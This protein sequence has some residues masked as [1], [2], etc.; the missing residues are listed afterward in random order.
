MPTA[1]ETI[2]T[3]TSWDIFYVMHQAETLSSEAQQIVVQKRA[4]SGNNN[5]FG[6]AC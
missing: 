1:E 2:L 6:K 4:H 3:I 5:I